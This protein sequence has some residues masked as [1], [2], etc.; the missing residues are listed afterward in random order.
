MYR[1]RVF[2]K[3]RNWA[4]CSGADAGLWE[5]GSARPL[6]EPRY[7]AP[8]AEVS[9]RVLTFWG[10]CRCAGSAIFK[11]RVRLRYARHESVVRWRTATCHL[12]MV[13]ILVPAPAPYPD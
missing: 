12:A 4:R 10:V 8:L 13:H 1:T 6:I 11:A 3:E 7:I 2:G 5:L 9:K